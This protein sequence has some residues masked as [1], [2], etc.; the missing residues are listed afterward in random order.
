MHYFLICFL[1][2]D[3]NLQ[4]LRREYELCLKV[5]KDNNNDSKEFEALKYN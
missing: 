3:E 4:K 5:Y 1:F 2:K